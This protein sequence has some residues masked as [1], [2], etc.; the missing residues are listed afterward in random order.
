MR[1]LG[2]PDAFP[3]TDLGIRFAARALGFDERPPLLM[4]HADRWRPW[5]AYATQYLWAT[6]DHAINRLPAEQDAPEDAPLASP[7]PAAH[8]VRPGHLVPAGHR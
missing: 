7:G 4:A 5:R 2:D 1:A 6:G 8:L 3:V